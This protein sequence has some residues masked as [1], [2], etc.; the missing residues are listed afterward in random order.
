MTHDRN[1]DPKAQL[2]RTR[3]RVAVFA[4]TV[5]AIGAAIPLVLIEGII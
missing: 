5:L 2:N 4:L 1:A 3:L